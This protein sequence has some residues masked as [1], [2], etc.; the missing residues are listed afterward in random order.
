MKNQIEQEQA[1]AAAMTNLKFE[2]PNPRIP[3]STSSASSCSNSVA[4]LN[5]APVHTVT[6]IS[7]L[8]NPRNFKG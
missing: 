2:V 5:F 8:Y 3:F 1:E 4:V 7:G 6:P